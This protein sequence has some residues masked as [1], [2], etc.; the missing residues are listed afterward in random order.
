MN[1]L[2]EILKNGFVSIEIDLL[3]KPRWHLD[4]IPSEPGWYFIETTAPIDIIRAVGDPK[5]NRNYDMPQKIIDSQ[6]LIDN[7]LSIKQIKEQPY[8][9][10]SGEA[11]NLLN[12]AREH[13]FGGKGTACLA[14]DKYPSLKSY[15][16]CFS[17]LTCKSYSPDSMGDKG[18]RNFGE[19]IWRSQNGWPVLCSQ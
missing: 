13:S 5:E 7:D 15:N 6:Y 9:V 19:Q 14:I 12:R 1:R 4:T 17:Y 8:I 11:E 10:Y 2:S 18:L 3:K 16:W